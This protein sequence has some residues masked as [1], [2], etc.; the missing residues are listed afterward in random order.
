AA[1]HAV[2]EINQPQLVPPDPE[3]G[4]DE[5][6][7]EANRSRCHRFP[8]TH[9]FHPTSKDSGRNT[10]EKNCETENPGQLRLAPVIR[11]GLRDS[12]NFGQRK[13]EDTE[14]VNLTNR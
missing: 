7:A 12:D 3:G 14:G 10:K 5:S 8:W 9:S 6:A 11:C 1:D 2:S 4:N 13:F